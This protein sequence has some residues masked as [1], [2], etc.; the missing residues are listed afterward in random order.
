MEAIAA[1][2]TISDRGWQGECLRHLFLTTMESSVEARHLRQFRPALAE[3]A[4]R[5]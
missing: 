1:H 3:Q 4:D 2:T 5:H